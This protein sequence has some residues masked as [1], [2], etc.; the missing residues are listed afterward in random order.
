MEFNQFVLIC[1]VA[2]VL[3][4]LLILSI[5]YRNRPIVKSYDSYLQMREGLAYMRSR[6]Y[7][8]IEIRFTE[9]VY[10]WNGEV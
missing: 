3:F 7:K 9:V 1:M 6:G 10:K 2:F 5:V 8:A 4:I